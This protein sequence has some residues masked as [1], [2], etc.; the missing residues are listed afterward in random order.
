MDN[1]SQ[2]RASGPDKIESGNSS[3]SLAEVAKLFFRLGATAFG[4]PAAHISMMHDEVVKRRKWLSDEQFLDLIGATN[5]IPGPNSTEMAM[6]IGYQ[7]AGWRGLLIGGLSFMAPAAVIVL[8]LS[9]VYVQFGS[10]PQITWLLYGVKPAVIAIILQALWSLG[11]KAIKGPL[12]AGTAVGVVVLYFAGTNEIALLLAGGLSVM[13]ARNWRN[14]IGRAAVIPALPLGG[15][16]A[17]STSTTPFNLAGLALNMLK[18]GAVWYGSGYV[19]LAFLRADFVERLHWLTD[20]QLIDAIAIGQITPGPIFTAATFI[21]YLLGGLS[22]ATV[23]T[24]AICLPSFV[25]VAISN[26]L[27]PRIRRSKYAGSLLDGVNL[28]ALALM[29]AVTWQLGRASL[30]DPFT[31]ILAAAAF[32]VLIRYRV[33][34]VWLV[35]GGALAGLI[36]SFFS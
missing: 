21:G 28:A 26:P 12:A 5:L 29:A 23:A 31:T 7:H 4:G 11:Q 27:I 9:W 32:L 3:G 14:L 35:L 34:S 16:L 30:I 6:H 24:I 8:I 13:I 33:N 1:L 2:S 20:Q 22:G 10:T 36:W 19:L 18:I 17:V 15:L 25:F